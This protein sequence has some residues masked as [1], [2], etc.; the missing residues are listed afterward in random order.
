MTYDINH[1]RGGPAGLTAAIYALRANKPSLYL[2]RT[3][4]RADDALP[5]IENYP[6]YECISGA[7]LADKMFGQAT[8]LGADIEIDE[9]REII[10]GATITVTP[11]CRRA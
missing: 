2:K 10:P 3:A 11:V 7:E 5:K 8:A 6:D 4:R 9:V 1:N